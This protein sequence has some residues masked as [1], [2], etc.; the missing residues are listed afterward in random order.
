MLERVCACVRVRARLAHGHEALALD[1]VRLRVQAQ[2]GGNLVAAREGRVREESASE[3][4]M[5]R[6]H[7]RARELWAHARDVAPGALV[8]RKVKERVLVHRVHNVLPARRR[9]RTEGAASAPHPETR[10]KPGALHR[11]KD[12]GTHISSRSASASN[13]RRASAA[14][15]SA[16]LTATSAR[17]HALRQRR[18][19]SAHAWVSACAA[20]LHGA[21]ARLRCPLCCARRPACARSAASRQAARRQRQ[22]GAAAAGA[23]RHRHSL[24][25]WGARQSAASR[26]ECVRK[27]RPWR[28]SA[29]GAADGEPAAASPGV[30]LRLICGRL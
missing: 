25:T 4:C 22:R 17:A 11:R 1:A 23:A 27:A 24:K 8:G 30:G 15:S 2:R 14:R 3:G 7:E 19:P 21:C 10:N 29:P 12:E 18:K 16:V 5:L 13:T 26:L 9:H 6:G 28:V 20:P